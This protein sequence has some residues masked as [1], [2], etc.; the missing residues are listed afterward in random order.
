MAGLAPP[1]YSF[2]NTLDQRFHEASSSSSPRVVRGVPR[3]PVTVS[4]EW[5]RAG[6]GGS[7]LAGRLR[8]F[9]DLATE[10]ARVHRRE[11]RRVPNRTL[12]GVRVVACFVGRGSRSARACALGAPKDNEKG[13]WHD[14]PSVGARPAGPAGA[15]PTLPR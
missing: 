15:A 8:S 3:V 9:T 12:P 13:S 14:G 7:H 10:K 6:M 2:Y 11:L 5:P 1:P 4:C